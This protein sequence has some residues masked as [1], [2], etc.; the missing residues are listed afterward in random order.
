MSTL[1]TAQ[2]T[3]ALKAAGSQALEV[4][5]SSN[6]GTSIG[7]P[8]RLRT[9]ASDM[10]SSGGQLLGPP[11]DHS[12]SDTGADNFQTVPHFSSSS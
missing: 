3:E 8:G 1:A 10:E 12:L 4:R 5:L 9:L 11:S 7:T 6:T 2:S